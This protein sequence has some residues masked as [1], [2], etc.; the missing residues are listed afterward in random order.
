MAQKNGENGQKGMKK[1][2]S[3]TKILTDDDL[4]DTKH[5]DMATIPREKSLYVDYA[6]KAEAANKEPT[7]NVA[8][9]STAVSIN[10]VDLS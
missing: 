1:T 3:G 5:T 9:E 8:R 6:L 4:T 7:T 10:A 2:N